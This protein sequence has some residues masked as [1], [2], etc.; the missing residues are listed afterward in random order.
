M[1]S[2]ND[3]VNEVATSK[4][5]ID[6]I[7]NITNTKYEEVL[8]ELA[9]YMLERPKTFEDLYNNT[10]YFKF[11][12]IKMI[13]NQFK[14]KTSYYYKNCVI[15]DSVQY[16]ILDNNPD[17]EY[18]INIDILIDQVYMVLDHIDDHLAV[19]IFKDYFFNNSSYRALGIKYECSHQFI[20][21]RIDKILD[22]LKNNM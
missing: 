9:F 2:I 15:N 14:S 16:D 22:I 4:E 6:I 3:I 20:K 1:K 21:I 19:E 12:F 13:T 11:F 17:E 10:N 7:K 18:D 8:S 5:Y